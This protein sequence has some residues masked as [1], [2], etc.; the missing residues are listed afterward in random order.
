MNFIF[1]NFFAIL[2]NK[3]VIQNNECRNCIFFYKKDL[4]KKFVELDNFTGKIIYQP[5]EDC[6]DDELKCGEKGKYFIDEK[7]VIEEE[8]E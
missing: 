5:V 1:L 7:E 6:R 2:S 3:K 8:I 4:C